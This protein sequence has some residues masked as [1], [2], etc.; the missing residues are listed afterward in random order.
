MALTPV[1]GLVGP[2]N[3]LGAPNASVEQSLNVMVQS[4]APR[5]TVDQSLNGTP[6][7]ERA[8][9]VEDSP[10][11]G[12]FYADG[13][14]FGVSGAV[15]F[16][17]FSD[18][19]TLTL[20]TVADDGTPATFASNGTAGNQLMV[21]AGGE[22][23]I[24]D[25][26]SGVVTHI[27]TADADFPSPVICCEFMDGYFFAVPR[28]SRQF[29]VS[30]LE[31]GLS[32]DPLDVGERSEGSDNITRLI[33]SHREIW[34]IGTQTTEV[35]YNNG[36]ALFPFAPIQGVFIEHGA[37]ATWSV[38]RL[39]ETLVWL[40]Q[41]ERGGGSVVVAKG[42]QPQAIS[43]YAMDLKIRSRAGVLQSAR[44][45]AMQMVGHMLYWLYVPGLTTTL[46]FDVTEGLWHERAHWNADTA[47]FEPHLASAH[48]WAFERHFVGDRASD[49]IYEMSPLFYGDGI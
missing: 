41:S 20:G 10:C 21:V 30:A 26:V 36:D 33:R 38:A 16:E 14:A 37:V 43:T 4:T 28:N 2:S 3:A 13:R 46:V 17:Q 40:D 24:Y 27:A 5:G 11:Y 49:L 31:D 18:D 23:Y 12:L 22:G 1:P 35:A 15:L 48:M 6:G 9:Q 44:G 25:L 29:Y 45:F 42:Y 19:T 47:S 34:V 8:C 32:W 39:E 7:I